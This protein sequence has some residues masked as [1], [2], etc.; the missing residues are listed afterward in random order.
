MLLQITVFLALFE[1][2]TENA[3]AASSKLYSFLLFLLINFIWNIRFFS[4]LIQS[5]FPLRLTNSL[6]YLSSNLHDIKRYS[7][8]LQMGT[9]AW[10]GYLPRGHSGNETLSIKPCC[11]LLQFNKA[12]L[13]VC[14][15]FQPMRTLQERNAQT[16]QHGRPIP[17]QP[18]PQFALSIQL[19]L[20]DSFPHI[21]CSIRLAA[22]LWICLRVLSFF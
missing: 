2:V 5:M 3:G 20:P 15:Y 21:P 13:D 1:G 6:S 11:L 4:V 16:L 14:S 17:S 22:V 18:G 9:K 12:G 10:R 7:Y 19:L 8:I